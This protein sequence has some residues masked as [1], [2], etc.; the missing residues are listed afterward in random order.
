MVF[1]RF[2]LPLDFFIT[3]TEYI[4]PGAC[5]KGIFTRGRQPKSAA[6][7]IKDRYKM[8][9]SNFSQLDYECVKRKHPK[10]D[11]IIV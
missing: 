9:N 4:R 1:L 8:L 5:V 2:F 7:V 11:I 10:G 6:Y 3:F